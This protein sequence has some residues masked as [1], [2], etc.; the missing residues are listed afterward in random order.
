MDYSQEIFKILGLFPNE[1]FILDDKNRRYRINLNLIV[2]VYIDGWIK[3]NIE[4]NEIL[5]GKYKICK[6]H[7]LTKNQQIAIDYAR[8]CGYKW[9][10]KYPYGTVLAFEYE[11]VKTERTWLKS[12]PDSQTMEI[13]TPMDFLSWQDE[14]PYYIGYKKEDNNYE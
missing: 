4:L 9:L 8:T 11:P 13:E 1:E 6:I 12:V 3:S 7:K 14:K 5:I 2:Q 10:V